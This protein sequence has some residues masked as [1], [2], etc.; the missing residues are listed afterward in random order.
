MDAEKKVVGERGSGR[1]GSSTW[2]LEMGDVRAQ[3]PGLAGLG[4]GRAKRERATGSQSALTALTACTRAAT[5]T[6]PARCRGKT[7]P[8]IVTAAWQQHRR[9]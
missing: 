9:L 2:L 4:R 3:R 1:W 6:A 7:K 5:T 8:S